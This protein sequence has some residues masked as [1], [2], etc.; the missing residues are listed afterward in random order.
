MLTLWAQDPETRERAR[1]ALPDDADV[2]TCEDWATFR[3]EL[4]GAR[5]GVVAAGRS[6]DSDLFAE[7]QLVRE[8]SANGDVPPS[9]VL[10]MPRTSA[11]LRRLGGLGADEVVWF[12]DLERELAPAVRRAVAERRFRD[13][14]QR[15]E[16]CDDLSPTLARALSRALSRR[17]PVTSVQRLAREVERDRRTLWHH[18][19]RSVDDGEQLTLKAFLDWIVLLR[20]A[21]ERTASQSW[22]EV[23]EEFGVHARTLRRAARRRTDDPL[24]QL[25]NGG[26]EACFRSF[27]DEVLPLLTEEQPRA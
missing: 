17:P 1:G 12:E 16:A 19:N 21:V 8:R 7:L 9:L 26:L 14:R 2:R 6:A 22:E 23:A 20:A 27:E 15:V 18:W 3:E 5:C 4:A 10:C 11:V 25:A 24:G 13:F